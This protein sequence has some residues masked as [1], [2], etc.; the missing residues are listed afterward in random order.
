MINHEYKTLDSPMVPFNL[1][2]ARVFLSE[3]LRGEEKASLAAPNVLPFIT[4]M[5]KALG[6]MLRL[7]SPLS[8]AK[9]NGRSTEDWVIYVFTFFLCSEPFRESH[10]KEMAFKIG[11]SV[12]LMLFVMINLSVFCTA[13]GNQTTGRPWYH[14]VC[15]CD[16]NR[17]FS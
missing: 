16:M 6:T 12:A 7:L 10:L 14:K 4:S 5:Q 17:C 9:K 15:L 11:L 1:F 3:I 13:G 2:M 8:I